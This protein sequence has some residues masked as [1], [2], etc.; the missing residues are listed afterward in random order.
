MRFHIMIALLMSFF[1]S[2]QLVGQEAN[3]RLFEKWNDRLELLDPSRPLDYFELAEEIAD[4]AQ[5]VNERAL[6]R[7]LFGLAGLL[8]R[9]TFGW[10]AAL[11]IADLE[12][13]PASRQRL[14]AAAELLAD[15]DQVDQSSK[16]ARDTSREGRLAFCRALGA[17]RRGDSARARRHL[18]KADAKVAME[19]F[20]FILP[21][22][23]QRFEN[24]LQVYSGGL[25]PDLSGQEI[26]SHLVAESMALAP[27]EAS[28]S[29]MLRATQSASLLVID[30][31]RLDRLF[32]VDPTRPFWREGRWVDRRAASGQ[33]G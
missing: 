23:G 17:L 27:R 19:E 33:G 29:V 10:S 13:L 25:R 24:D 8:D 16:R 6:A 4:G 14:L 32:G 3:V 28:W 30:L 20:I 15:S 31:D 26:E 11:A 1:L 22:G 18:D 5:T 21:G 9:E 7:E 2:S 12:S